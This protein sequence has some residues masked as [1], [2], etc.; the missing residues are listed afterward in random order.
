MIS[1]CFGFA[2][3][4]SCGPFSHELCHTLTDHRL[5]CSAVYIYLFWGQIKTCLYLMYLMV[6]LNTHNLLMELIDIRAVILLGDVQ[7]YG[8]IRTYSLTF[9]PWKLFSVLHT[10]S[11]IQAH[12]FIRCKNKSVIVM[13]ERSLWFLKDIARRSSLIVICFTNSVAAVCYLSTVVW[14]WP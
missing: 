10:W 3:M 2:G 14:F 13:C 6:Y 8:I 5:V 1:K 12:P 11:P 9:Y 7:P 4:S